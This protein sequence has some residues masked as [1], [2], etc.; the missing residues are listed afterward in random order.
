MYIRI[1][2][3]SQ[4]VPDK[5]LRAL[6]LRLFAEFYASHIGLW[7][8]ERGDFT[9]A[10]KLWRAVR[11]ERKILAHLALQKIAQNHRV[12]AVLVLCGV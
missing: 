11:F 10:L 4:I 2:N 9:F 1:E 5:A 12:V 6:R 7:I 8:G 3:L